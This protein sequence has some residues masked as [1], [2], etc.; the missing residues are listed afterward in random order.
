MEWTQA[1]REHAL[2]GGLP[3]VLGLSFIDSAGL[4]T[5][6]G[7]DVAVVVLTGL[8]PFFHYVALLVLAASLGSTAGCVVL[9]YVGRRGGAIALQRFAPSKREYVRERIARN[10]FA[11]IFLSAMGPPPFPTK[12]FVLSAGVFGMPLSTLVLSMLTGRLLRYSIA[13]YLGVVLGER[14][15][16]FLSDHAGHALIALLLVAA[17][18]ALVH[19]IRRRGTV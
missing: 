7:P 9:Y 18:F 3:G 6:G 14:A 15:L 10:G 2:D 17:L 4:P 1:L 5:G 13:G 16:L 8:Q 12:L 11:A 19:V